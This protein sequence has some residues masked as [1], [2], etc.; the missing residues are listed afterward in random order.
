MTGLQESSMKY[1]EKHFNDR[2]LKFV[3]SFQTSSN[4]QVINKGLDVYEGRGLE[5]EYHVDQ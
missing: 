4:C 3:Y 5:G 1:N 2:L